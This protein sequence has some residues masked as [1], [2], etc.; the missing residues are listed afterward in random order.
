MNS[1]ECP[2]CH[3]IC[4]STT[5]VN[6]QLGKAHPNF[7][8]D[9][10]A[11][12]YTRDHSHKKNSLQEAQPITTTTT[13]S[14]TQSLNENRLDIQNPP[15][16]PPNVM[17]EWENKFLHLLTNGSKDE[18]ESLTSEALTF[19]A[20]QIAHLPGPQHPAIK[21]YKLRKF[22]KTKNKHNFI[23]TSNPERRPKRQREKNRQ[24]YNYEV[25]QYNFYNHRKKVAHSILQ[26]LSKHKTCQ[27]PIGDIYEHFNATFNIINDNSCLPD[28]HVATDLPSDIVISEK[29]IHRALFQIKADTSTGPVRI[30]VRIL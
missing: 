4:K 19:I 15:Y 3:K 23:S 13:T 11:N 9:K 20:D 21:Y 29:D 18:F 2:I 1:P 7:R 17:A 5:G 14:T 26:N 25:A 24:H 27:I 10:I 22:N 16:S 6:I 8:R 28:T 30:T 12:T